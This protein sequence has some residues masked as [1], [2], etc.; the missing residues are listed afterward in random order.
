MTPKSETMWMALDKFTKCHVPQMSGL[1][2]EDCQ[3][4][5]NDQIKEEFADEYEPDLVTIQPKKRGKG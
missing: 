1:T 5:I 2:K 3:K 4:A